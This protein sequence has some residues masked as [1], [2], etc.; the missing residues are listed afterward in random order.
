MFH[1]RSFE[2]G[3]SPLDQAAL[4]LFTAWRLVHLLR[5]S[6]YGS[7]LGLRMTHLLGSKSAQLIWISRSSQLLRGYL[8]EV[9][10]MVRGGTTRA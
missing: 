2:R 10:R 6:P 4:T 9:G 8:P 7:D 1:K 3:P 5:M